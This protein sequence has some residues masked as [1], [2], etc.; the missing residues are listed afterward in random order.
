MFLEIFAEIVMH[1]YDESNLSIWFQILISAIV[2]GGLTAFFT[3]IAL[4]VYS[5]NLIA[6]IFC[7]IIPTVLVCF[8]IYDLY[9]NLK[10]IRKKYKQNKINDKKLL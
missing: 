8:Y 7:F 4:T 3:L 5:V 10:F 2:V 9:R 6:G 1:K